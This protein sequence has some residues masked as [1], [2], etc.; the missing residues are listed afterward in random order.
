MNTLIQYK[1]T[2]IGAANYHE[3]Q[4]SKYREATIGEAKYLK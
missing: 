1:T 2:N 4:R 3:A